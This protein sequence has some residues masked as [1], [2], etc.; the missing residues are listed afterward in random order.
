MK[1]LSVVNSLVSKYGTRDPFELADKLCIYVFFENLGSIN[2]YYSTAF[3]IK[4]IHINEKLSLK[5]RELTCAHE[6]GH[7]VM[8]P[9]LNI[10]FMHQNTHVVEEK[11]EKQANLFASHLLF[12]DEVL[13][14]YEGYSAKE[15]A[16]LLEI[17]CHILTMRCN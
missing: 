2:G 13:M 15:I 4:I 10:E 1:P 11:Y 8:H 9:R 14:E 16:S 7:A 3:G 12:P 6:L 5:M 17:P